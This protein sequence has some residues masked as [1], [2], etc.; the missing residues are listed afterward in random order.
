[1]LWSFEVGREPPVDH[2]VLFHHASRKRTLKLWQSGHVN[3]RLT[4]CT[5]NT[6]EGTWIPTGLDKAGLFVMQWI[7]QYSRNCFAKHGINASRSYYG[8]VTGKHYFAITHP[9]CRWPPA[10]RV[11]CVT[12][13]VLSIPVST[14]PRL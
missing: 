12:N 11:G 13:V 8:V 9:A 7:L 5:C 6:V 10:H 2:R 3:R 1:M 14:V 4:A